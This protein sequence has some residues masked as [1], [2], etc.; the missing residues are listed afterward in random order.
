MIFIIVTTGHMFGLLHPHQGYESSDN[1]VKRD[2]CESSCIETR[3][4]DGTRGDFVADT[5]SFLILSNIL[6]IMFVSLQRR[7]ICCVINRKLVNRVVLVNGLFVFCFKKI[8]F[9]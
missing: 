7:Q 3:D 9:F 1:K 4:N 2:M 8:V 5:V 6:I